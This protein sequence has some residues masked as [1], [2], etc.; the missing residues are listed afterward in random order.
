MSSYRLDRH[1]VASALLVTGEMG[2]SAQS[3]TGT[4]LGT[5]VDSTGAAISDATVVLRILGT[6]EERTVKS[7][8]AGAYT[9]PN[10]QVGHYSVI[11]SHEG[12]AQTQV[13]DSELEVAQ[14]A[15]INATLRAGAISDKV[16]V[17]ASATPLLN[18]ASSS[19]GQVINTETVQN[20]PLNGRNFWQLTQLTP[21]GTSIRA[22]AVNVNVNGCRRRGQAGISTARTSQSLNWAARSSR[23]PW[24]RCRSSRWSPVTCP[25]TTATAP[26]S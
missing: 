16:E 8:A 19:V 3:N 6:A 7:D 2:I 10:L 4:I 15:T 17:V 5:V 18:E 1:A 25:R 26:P 20:V 12:F 22:R 21:G 23:R 9:V 24:T 11:V 14:R 13:A